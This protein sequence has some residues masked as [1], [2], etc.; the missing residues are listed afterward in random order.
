MNMNTT[1]DPPA[2]LSEDKVFI[3]FATKT[4]DYLLFLSK[5]VKS[6]SISMPDA[7]KKL[8]KL[9]SKNLPFAEKWLTLT[10][11]LKQTFRKDYKNTW[12]CIKV[13]GII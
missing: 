10:L 13:I 2:K 8:S 6:S 9:Q 4:Y 3:E 1:L 5:T 11:F 7:Q 12:K